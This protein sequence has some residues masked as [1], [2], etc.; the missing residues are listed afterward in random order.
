MKTCFPLFFKE[1]PELIDYPTNVC[2]LKSPYCAHNPDKTAP[3]WGAAREGAAFVLR[4]YSSMYNKAVV[5][6]D[7]LSYMYDTKL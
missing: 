2:P 6:V 3:S 5:V 7:L 4:R 1:E